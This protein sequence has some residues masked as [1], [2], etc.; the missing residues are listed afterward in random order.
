MLLGTI[1]QLPA[2]CQH[3]LRIISRTILLRWEYV[4]IS[5]KKGAGRNGLCISL[6]ICL[7]GVGGVG[8]QRHDIEGDS[9]ERDNDIISK[10]IE[11]FF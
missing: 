8:I 4:N 5:S 6:Y 7:S 9:L 1:N 2:N 3:V 10:M 11:F